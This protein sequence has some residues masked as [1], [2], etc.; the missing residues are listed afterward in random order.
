MFRR[1]A[2]T[3]TA[4]LPHD[5]GGANI[6]AITA[7]VKALDAPG[8]GAAKIASVLD[9][10]RSRF[11]W[12]YGSYW[13][14]AAPGDPLRF[15]QESGDVSPEFRRVT[16]EATFQE[17]VGL[18]GKAWKSR[19]LVVV[20]DLGAVTDCVRAPVARKVGVR[21]AVCFPIVVN[22]RVVATMD[23]M[24]TEQREVS[25]L[26]RATLRSIGVLVSQALTRS[27]VADAQEAAAP[28]PRR[29]EQGPARHHHG[30]HL[31]GRLQR[32]PGHDPRRLRLGVRLL[33]GRR[34]LRRRPALRAG[35]RQ[36]G[37][38]VP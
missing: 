7:V 36:R 20:D 28:R 31:R 5:E 1:A 21:S 19:D 33:L 35:V 34:S 2:R 14:V 9:L 29:R 22:D 25:P 27:K 26:R 17:G 6:D 3:S 10:V 8:T 13:V 16:A 18:S 23:F 11:G 38:R 24:S 15:A 12:S 37:R 32:R 4:S 30:D